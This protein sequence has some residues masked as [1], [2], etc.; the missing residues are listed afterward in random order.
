[1]SARRR[2]LPPPA[3]GMGRCTRGDG[4][5]SGSQVPHN[6][7]RDNRR[8]IRTI[9]LSSALLVALGGAAQAQTDP[10]TAAAPVAPAA[11]NARPWA[12]RSA[13][14]ALRGAYQAIAEAQALGASAYLDAAKTHYRGAVARYA[15]HDAGAASEAMAAAALARASMAEH[16]APAPRDIPAPPAITAMAEPE[17]RPGG[18]AERMGPP[19]APGR[20]RGPGGWGHGGPGGGRFDPAELA[21][22]AQLVNT[23]EAK[24]LAQKALD[25]DLARTRAAFGGNVDEAMRQ[26]RLANDLAGAV[27]SLALADHPPVRGAGPRVGRMHRGSAGIVG[28]ADS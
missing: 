5:T 11:N 23:A 4:G 18:P 3:P 9:A 21:T 16:P 12:E 1:M 2:F 8:M 19:G 17:R 22:F 13:T 28:G 7:L 6:G 20:E 24:E 15:R 25:A 27:R 14:Y 26:G 10:Q